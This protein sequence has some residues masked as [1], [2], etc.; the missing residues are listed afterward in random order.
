MTE[1]AKDLELILDEFVQDVRRVEDDVVSFVLFGTAGRGG[2]IPGESDLMDAYVFLRREVFE[3]K[4]RFFRAIEVLSG[5]FVRYAEKA[6]F[7][8]HSYF[9]WDERDPVP[10]H[11]RREMTTFSKIIL[12]DDIRDRIESTTPSYRAG[13]AAFFE[14]RKMGSPLMVLLHKEELTEKERQ[15]VYNGLLVIVK[16]IPMSACMALNI[17]AGL[18]EAVQELKTALPDLNTEVLDKITL[19]R[20]EPD[21]TADSEVLHT[22]LR[23]GMEFVEDLNNRLVAKL[24]DELQP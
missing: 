15:A 5:A 19:L 10:G 23:E 16:H 4:A 17:W 22:L 1:T 3:D 8:V 18:P 13:R 14:I 7:P 2:F 9:Y 21:R 24:T 12:G 20:Y 11:F 6:P